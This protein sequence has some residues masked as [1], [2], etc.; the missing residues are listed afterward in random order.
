MQGSRRRKLLDFS[1]VLS[2]SF[3]SLNLANG[4]WISSNSYTWPKSTKS[5]SAFLSLDVADCRSRAANSSAA[6]DQ[7]WFL[8]AL[9]RAP[10]FLQ[11]LV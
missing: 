10:H 1:R 11:V 8:Q 3:P 7:N 2:L 4:E 9:V 6:M 5:P